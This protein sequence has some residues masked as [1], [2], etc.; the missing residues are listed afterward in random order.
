MPTQAPAPSQGG[1]KKQPAPRAYPFPVGVYDVE[2]QDGGTMSLVQT[3][4][5]QQFPIYNVTPDGW[6]RGIWFDFTMTTASNAATVAFQADAPFSVIN[7]VTLRDL[8]QQA[9]IGP[10]GGYDWMTLNKFGGYEFIGDPRADLTYSVTAGSGATGGSFAFSLYLPFEFVA[11]DALGVVDNTSKPGWTVEIWMDAST[12]VY[13]TSPTTLGTLVIAAYPVGYTKPVGAAPTGRPF[14]QTPPKAGTLQYWVSEGG[15]GAFNG[16]FTYDLVNGISFPLRN[17]LYKM[18]AN[19]NGTRATG[20]GYWPSPATLQYGNVIM[21]AI[22]KNRWINEQQNDFFLTNTTADGALGR[23]N[24]VFPICRAKDFYSIAGDELR[25]KYLNTQQGT[26]VRLSGSTGGA[27]L[28]YVLVNYIK[29]V[30]KSYYGL[31][32]A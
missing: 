15:Q 3:T 19:S 5:P 16:Q 20:D 29:P 22:S 4:A 12:A 25:Y 32:A 21:K 27:A 17:W 11:R 9:V 8:G 31:I 18:V 24:G 2:A 1:Q 23:E 28:L 13:S 26:L 14:A 7:K 30:D 10:I 6:L